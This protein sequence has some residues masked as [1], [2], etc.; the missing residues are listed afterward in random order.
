MNQQ[1]HIERLLMISGMIRALMITNRDT[2][3]EVIASYIDE[4]LDDLIEIL[5]SEQRLERTSRFQALHPCE[6][7]WKRIGGSTH[8]EFMC[9]KC[10][11]RG[12]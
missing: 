9:A 6:H 7:Q 2:P 4:M 5:Q 8:D 11:E 1:E 3:A 10:G 12:E